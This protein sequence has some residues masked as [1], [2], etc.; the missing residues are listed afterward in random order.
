MNCFALLTRVT[1]IV[2]VEILSTDALN[3]FI[4][5][6]Y[7]LFGQKTSNCGHTSGRLLFVPYHSALLDNNAERIVNCELFSYGIFRFESNLAQF[8][9]CFYCFCIKTSARILRIVS[10][11]KNSAKILLSFLR[12]SF[13]CSEVLFKL[14]Y[15]YF[16]L[17]LS[18][19]IALDKVVLLW[20]FRPTCRERNYILKCVFLFNQVSPLDIFIVHVVIGISSNTVLLAFCTDQL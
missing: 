14:I 15:D 4:P 20:F 3:I 16:Y 2:S 19:C 11:S 13:D 6:E 5:F 12:E 17:Q 18:I 8:A 9:N 7:L 10:S 1:S